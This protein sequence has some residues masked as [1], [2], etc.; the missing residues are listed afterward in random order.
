MAEIHATVIEEGLDAVGSIL[1]STVIICTW[2]PAGL[3]QSSTK[4]HVLVIIYEPS[5]GPSA[6]ISL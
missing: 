3:S 4:L 5:Q 2:S 1:S 6:R